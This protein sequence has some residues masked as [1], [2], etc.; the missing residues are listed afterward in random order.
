LDS[1]ETSGSTFQLGSGFGQAVAVDGEIAV[2]GSH[3][4]EGFEGTGSATV[5]M[6]QDG[7]WEETAELHPLDY[8]FHD[9]FGVSVALSG[10]AIVVGAPSEN[11][12]GFPPPAVYVFRYDGVSWNQ[13]AKLSS[14]EGA[15]AFGRYVA[16]SGDELI[17]SAKDAMYFFRVNG[18]QW[19]QEQR[20]T[21]L[22]GPLPVAID[23][24]VA[25]FGGNVFRRYGSTW[26]REPFLL[27]DGSTVFTIDI[28]P[29]G[30]NRVSVSNDVALF[31]HVEGAVPG[32][33]IIY[34]F[35]GSAWA[36]EEVIHPA[37]SRNGDYFGYSVASSGNRIVVGSPLSDGNAPGTG[38]AFV[39]RF[40]GSNWIQ[41]STLFA[42]KTT[43]QELFGYAVAFDG[44]TA[45][46]GEPE[47]FGL[48][49]STGTAYTFRLGG[50][51]SCCNRR[52]G[53]CTPCA[54]QADC[55]D[56]DQSWTDGLGCSQAECVAVMGACCD[57]AV[58]GNA[59]R[60]E[61]TEATLVDCGC[62]ACEWSIDTNCANTACA[63]TYGQI[64]TVSEWGLIALSLSLLIGAKI[65]YSRQSFV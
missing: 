3:V 50:V 20:V 1:Q 38:A 19:V 32:F 41:E 65:V 51:G 6:F 54:S 48:A 36:F 21:G 46:V 42:P 12:G 60:A 18:V 33:A 62:P 64:P 44:V 27:E 8:P 31:G 25:L 5:F 35:N 49:D 39:F 2:V 59:T 29:F 47:G 14:Q 23:Q 7:A 45:L 55:N 22:G 28:G 9:R 10:T 17:V 40:N 43:L 24:D 30:K 13:E 56:S 34:R 57:R 4:D 52:L 61:C 37:T 53:T 63:P 11:A 58:S 15:P 26:V 16:I